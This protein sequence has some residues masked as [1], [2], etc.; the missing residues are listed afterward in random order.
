VDSFDLGKDEGIE[1]RVVSPVVSFRVECTFRD[2]AVILVKR[3]GVS[4]FSLVGA[5]EVF[6]DLIVIGEETP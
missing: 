6:T 2:D 1:L 3:V 5:F 4:V